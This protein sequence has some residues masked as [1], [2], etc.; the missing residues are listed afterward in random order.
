ML[1]I[2]KVLSDMVI[3]QED[4]KAKSTDY[5]DGPKAKDVARV[6]R[7]KLDS[8]EGIIGLSLLTEDVHR[9]RLAKIIGKFDMT[10]AD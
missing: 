7:L 5:Q 2:W 1:P 9:V 10:H 3:P 8:G 6:V 4:K